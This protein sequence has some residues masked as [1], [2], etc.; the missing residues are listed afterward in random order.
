MASATRRWLVL[1]VIVGAALR[2]VPIWFGLPYPQARPDEE[3][4]VGKA[5]EVLGGELNPRFFHWPS[6]TFYV[7]AGVLGA[8]AGMREALGIEGQVHFAERAL[9]ARGVIALAG[10]VT[11]IVLFRLTQRVSGDTVALLAAA[12][13]AV[14]I[15]HVRESHFAMTD[16]LMTLLLWTALSLILDA[17]DLPAPSG[18]ARRLSAVA[19]LAAGLATSTKY[20]AAAVGV[21]MAATQV[22]WFWRQPPAALTVR[23][24]LPSMLFGTAMVAGFLIA[25]P[26]A[27]L[28]YPT[29][30]RDLRFDF[31]HLAQGH[32][33]NL[34]RGWVYHATHSLPYG[35]GLAACAAA[36]VGL[37]PF[38]RHHGRAAFVL[39]T[40]GVAFYLAIGNGYTVF[41][42]YVLPLVPLVCLL[43]A[44]GVNH[45][46][47]WLSRRVGMPAAGALALVAGLALGPG[48]VASAWFDV[49]LARTDTRVLA[50]EWLIPQLKPGETLHDAGGNYTQLD[51]WRATFHQWHYDPA[52]DSFGAPD[53]GTP[54]WLVLH[55]SP[56]FTYTSTPPLLT[57]LARD[58]YTRVFSVRGTRNRAGV[59]DLQD[60]FF[61]PVSGFGSI[62]RPGPNISIYRRR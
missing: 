26:Y 35:V 59:Y 25:T 40:F 41:F 12:F 29:F 13:L 34:G 19:G 18:A 58:R 1:I 33:V 39:G 43:A 8:A 14:A 44:V 54:D 7:L 47:R 53:G 50:A 4:A 9:I 57:R 46:A 2:F 48:L 61:L 24:S 23:G 15:L 16:V 30:S 55:D 5:V 31:T 49:L 11:L 22:L 52:A 60:A 10:T 45:T 38:A 6:L 56:V 28:D 20:S 17:G 51:L 32:G 27:A 3:T 62:L 36:L 37:V 21:A 42:R